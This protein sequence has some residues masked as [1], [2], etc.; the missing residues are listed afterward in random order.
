MLYISRLFKLLLCFKMSI[1]K[2][3]L[4]VNINSG[5]CTISLPVDTT[6]DNVCSLV[7]LRSV[8]DIS[9]IFGS[10]KDFYYRRALEGI[11][12]TSGDFFHYTKDDGTADERCNCVLCWTFRKGFDSR[13]EHPANY[14]KML[15]CV[16]QLQKDNIFSG[17]EMVDFA[18]IARAYNIPEDAIVH[19]WKMIFGNDDPKAELPSLQASI[20]GIMQP[21]DMG[22]LIDHEGVHVDRFTP[23]LNDKIKAVQKRYDDEF[24]LHS[25]LRKVKSLSGHSLN[26]RQIHSIVKVMKSAHYPQKNKKSL[27]SIGNRHSK[28]SEFWKHKFLHDHLLRYIGIG[29]IQRVKGYK[30]FKDLTRLADKEKRLRNRLAIMGSKITAVETGLYLLED[31]QLIPVRHAYEAFNAEFSIFLTPIERKNFKILFRLRDGMVKTTLSRDY[32]LSNTGTFYLALLKQFAQAMLD[33][34]SKQVTWWK[35]SLTRELQYIRQERYIWTNSHSTDFHTNSMH[36]RF[37][38]ALAVRDYIRSGRT[39]VF[40]RNKIKVLDEVWAKKVV[41]KRSDY[42]ENY[43]AEPMM[44]ILSDFPQNLRDYITHKWEEYKVRCMKNFMEAYRITTSLHPETPMTPTRAQVIL[45]SDINQAGLIKNWDFYWSSKKRK[46]KTFFWTRA[47]ALHQYILDL[48]PEPPSVFTQALLVVDNKVS[49]LRMK[50]M[51]SAGYLEIGN[52]VNAELQLNNLIFNSLTPSTGQMDN[53]LLGNLPH[54]E[55]LRCKRFVENAKEAV[56]AFKRHYYEPRGSRPCPRTKLDTLSDTKIFK[57]HHL[58]KNI[59]NQRELFKNIVYEKEILKRS[60]LS[61]LQRDSVNDWLKNKYYDIRLW[62][63]EGSKV[64]VYIDYQKYAEGEIP[65]TGPDGGQTSGGAAQT[66][67]D[68]SQTSGGGESKNHYYVAASNF[69]AAESQ[70]DSWKSGDDTNGIHQ[71]WVERVD[72]DTVRVR[73]HQDF[74]ITNP[75]R[76][77]SLVISSVEVPFSDIYDNCPDYKAITARRNRENEV[78]RKRREEAD[79]ERNLMLERRQMLIGLTEDELENKR[80]GD[81]QTEYLEEINKLMHSV[82]KAPD[83]LEL[84]EEWLGLLKAAV[85]KNTVVTAL[86]GKCTQEPHLFVMYEDG[87]EQW[88]KNN[89]LGSNVAYKFSRRSLTRKEDKRM[90][91][92]EEQSDFKLS[93]LLIEKFKDTPTRVESNFYTRRYIRYI[94]IY[95]KNEEGKEQLIK[96]DILKLMLD[97]VGD[98]RKTF[99]DAFRQG[100]VK[101]TERQDALQ[102][103][104]YQAWVALQSQKVLLSQAGGLLA[105]EQAS[106]M[107]GK[108][109]NRK[110]SD[111]V[112]Q[113]RSRVLA[114]IDEIIGKIHGGDENPR[115]KDER[116]ENIRNYIQTE[117][118]DDV[119]RQLKTPK[120]VYT[121][122]MWELEV[123]KSL[124]KLTKSDFARLEDYVKKTEKRTFNIGLTPDDVDETEY[125]RDFMVIRDDSA[126]YPV[127]SSK[128][129]SRESAAFAPRKS[130]TSA[131]VR[132]AYGRNSWFEINQSADIMRITGLSLSE[133]L[134][135]AEDIHDMERDLETNRKAEFG[136]EYTLLRKQLRAVEDNI[137]SETKAI[138]IEK[139]WKPSDGDGSLRIVDDCVGSFHF[140]LDTLKQVRNAVPGEPTHVRLN[141]VYFDSI[142]GRGSDSK[143]IRKLVPFYIVTLYSAAYGR[144]TRMQVRNRASNTFLPRQR[145]YRDYK[146]PSKSRKQKITP[147]YY[148]KED[149]KGYNFS[150]CL[151]EREFLELTNKNQLEGSRT[152]VMT[153]I[154]DAFL[155]KYHSILYEHAKGKM[156]TSLIDKKRGVES[157]MQ[158][159]TIE[160]SDDASA[161]LSDGL[162][163]LGDTGGPIS[164]HD[165]VFSINDVHFK[166]DG[167]ITSYPRYKYDIIHVNTS[168]YNHTNGVKLLKY[169]IMQAAIKSNI[170]FACVIEKNWTKSV[171]VYTY[172]GTWQGKTIPIKI[173][174]NTALKWCGDTLLVVLGNVVHCFDKNSNYTKTHELKGHTGV[175]NTICVKENVGESLANVIVTGSGDNSLIAWV[176]GVPKIK[177]G[178]RVLAKDRNKFRFGRVV[179]ILSVELCIV[180]LFKTPS[181]PKTKK[182]GRCVC[183]ASAYLKSMYAHTDSVMEVTWGKHIVSSS[184]DNTVRIWRGEEGNLFELLFTVDLIAMGVPAQVNPGPYADLFKKSNKSMQI[185]QAHLLPPGSAVYITAVPVSNVVLYCSGKVLGKLDVDTGKRIPF[186]DDIVNITSGVITD[187]GG[188]SNEQSRQRRER[189]TMGEEDSERQRRERRERRERMTMGEEDSD[190]EEDEDGKTKTYRESDAYIAAVRRNIIAERAKKKKLTVKEYM[191]LRREKKKRKMIEWQAEQARVPVKEY[192][193][194]RRERRTAGEED[195]D[196]YDTDEWQDVPADITPPAVEQEYEEQKAEKVEEV[197]EEDSDAYDIDE[198][199]DDDY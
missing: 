97:K 30:E 43:I 80:R 92:P 174:K 123:D 60:I 4:G 40:N 197:G 38:V 19:L 77:Q 155:H 106:I 51:Q 195:S 109:V 124:A 138:Q 29:R 49:A 169:S 57:T 119:V 66:G 21:V 79:I 48:N 74:I 58:F 144:Y 142:R 129:L 181:Q 41:S 6:Y 122:Q 177:E 114:I 84:F 26:L 46:R 171:K 168:L 88:L 2:S 145:K 186:E 89:K 178:E 188:T 160:D 102:K 185:S 173:V 120:R 127:P 134:Q 91:T 54:N 72:S 139:N 42:V 10:N 11:G 165:G 1:I 128:E 191:K 111:K 53:F 16:D 99:I 167:S 33:D 107:E 61:K 121:E 148:T 59:D 187:T 157:L 101:A 135:M 151:S 170:L 36:K 115:L 175:I 73:A 82:E 24:E 87:R 15:C 81:S 95:S 182:P 125:Q 39:A 7:S 5:G 52:K 23:S 143:P 45:L 193:R 158:E 126:V 105:K 136:E 86:L 150:L 152:R 183:E 154:P 117:M 162:I 8:K 20:E 137:A 64:Y 56:N 104:S 163:R 198:W 71:A 131:P 130:T 192:T 116:D 35:P 75:A 78:E 113:A 55:R 199:E 110:A 32:R 76:H 100:W 69:A 176:G 44:S 108:K 166:T 140:D 50:A 93:L 70:D 27:E 47:R 153:Q 12:N 189:R 96:N 179:R 184:R 18:K 62:V 161:P 147:L 98:D 118:D 103:K 156:E 68:E 37:D 133:R 14:A 196:A 63:F 149:Y 159:L 146:P 190:A 94:C 164:Y 112:L 34:G 141:H 13:F 25:R 83:R 172:N 194:Q 180:Q 22:N 31:L 17:M 3:V 90:R 9:L 85:Q 67:S 28:L 65:Q 132:V